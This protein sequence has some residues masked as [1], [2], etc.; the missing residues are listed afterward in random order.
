MT[1]LLHPKAC[2]KAM[3]ILDT[4]LVELASYDERARGVEV[5]EDKEE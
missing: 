3:I 2:A 1:E 4:L 5:E